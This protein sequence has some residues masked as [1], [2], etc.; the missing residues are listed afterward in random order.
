[1]T[2]K[3]SK[4]LSV[5]AIAFVICAVQHAQQLPREQWGAMPVTVSHEAGKWIIAGQ[6][7]RLTINETDLALNVQAGPAQWVMVPSK[8]GDMLVKSRGEEVSLRLAGA[9]TISV[10]PYDTGFKTGVKIH[11]AGWKQKS[12]NI[13]LELL[14][15]VCLQELMSTTPRCA[16]WTGPPR[17]MLAKLITRC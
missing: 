2:L 13:E 6:K 11:L 17:S 10:V 16:S 9:K 3:S 1:M 14:L 5:I 8:A 4:L 12:N 15:T 7:N